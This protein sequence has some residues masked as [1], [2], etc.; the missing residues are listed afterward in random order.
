[1]AEVERLNI[2]IPPVLRRLFRIL[3]RF[4]LVQIPEGKL[5]FDFLLESRIQ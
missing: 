2:L 4:V 1:M 5:K 3:G